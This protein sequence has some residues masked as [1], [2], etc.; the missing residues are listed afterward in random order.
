MP[1]EAARR[2]RWPYRRLAL[3]VPLAFIVLLVGIPAAP[4]GGETGSKPA[5]PGTPT[6]AVAPADAPFA[7][8]TTF[9]GSE[10]RSGYSPAEGP[11]AAN[12]LWIQ[13][14]NRVAI[15]A[16]PVADATR[17]IFANSLGSVSAYA[18]DRNGTLLWNRSIG[19][20]PTTGDLVGDRVLFGSGGGTITTL[21][22]STGTPVWSVLVGGGGSPILQGIS[23]VGS[24]AFALT[25]AG[26][27]VALNLSTGSPEWSYSLGSRA[28]GALAYSGGELFAVAA[29]GT[30]DAISLNG[31][32]TW[33]QPVGAPVSTGPAVAD[34]HVVVADRDGNVTA[35]TPSNGS[36]LW[37]WSASA[38]HRNDSIEATPAVAPGRVYVVTD[39]GYA[40]ALNGSNGALLW[41]HTYG[42]SGYPVLASPVATPTMV[43]FVDGQEFVDGVNASSGGVVWSATLGFTPAFGSPALDG[44]DLFIGN[45]VGCV[46]AFGPVGGP[47][48][49]SVRGVV[50]TR[51]GGLVPGAYL[52]AGSVQ[53][54]SGPA[55]EFALQ[56]PNGSYVLQVLASGF[57]PANLSITVRGPLT[58]LRVVLRPLSVYLLVGVVEDGQ[59]GHPLG[60]AVVNVGGPF[61][62]SA[63]TVADSGGR[64]AIPAPN[65]SVYLTVN[66]PP[67]YA[68]FEERLTVAG[69]PLAGLRLDL[70]PNAPAAALDGLRTWLLVLPLAAVAGAGVTLYVRET[71]R[72]RV[73]MGLPPA[74]LSPFGRF[75][76]MRA[77]LI[78]VQAFAVLTVLYLFGAYLP[79]LARSAQPQLWNGYWLFID[80]LFTG[81]WGTARFGNLVAPNAQLLSWW[82]PDSLELALLAL[83]L[84]AAIAYPLGLSAGWRRDG[85]LD[86]G[87]RVSSLL[88]L[89]VPSFL[90]ALFLI[91]GVYNPF[92]SVV[93]DD[94][95]GNF[96]SPFWFQSHGGYPHWIGF[97]DNT[98]PTGFPLIDGLLHRDWP[99][100]FVV[101]AK[102]LLQALVIAVIYVAIFLRYARHTVAEVMAEPHVV[103][104]RARGIPDS[105]ILWRHGRA[106][107]LPLFVLIFGLT[108]PAYVGT[109]ALVEALANDNGVGT[110]LIAQM[111]RVATNRFGF[112]GISSTN[113]PGNFYQVT[114][115]LLLLIVL[116]VN[117]FADVVARYLDPRLASKAAR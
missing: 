1:R 108:L 65:G 9:H 88:A 48:Q 83:P 95:F 29:N 92:R 41:S 98:S 2:G 46:Y 94:P 22:A 55:G 100:E 76:A 106:R 34:G 35:F 104:A 60:G 38:L 33:K 102:S 99:F 21:N 89:L 27:L 115:F 97:A 50:A 111:S 78:P 85:W 105:V 69:A 79:A 47:P 32:L 5:I 25:G 23:V 58:G 8:W 4:P 40:S 109:Q 84:S 112:S 10:N 52:S 28:G 54:L 82:L 93:G 42:Y 12:A 64:F 19:T 87:V 107:V 75:V 16:G 80:N 36:R 11:S 113:A 17:V 15:R 44:G 14:C 71:S 77:I 68:G 24:T 13:D 57:E 37:R 91:D 110:L 117:L 51:A 74:V 6:A 96:P 63:S 26:Q 90:V 3:L 7:H 39:F 30:I 56:L 18:R 45:E 67:G 101:L 72:R 70:A 86:N 43:Y 116:V 49:Y 20:S 62:Y 81:N 66:P 114:V 53:A 31:V 61:A 59:S 103:A 73:A